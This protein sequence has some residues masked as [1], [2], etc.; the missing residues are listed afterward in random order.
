M[1]RWESARRGLQ[2]NEF[3]TLDPRHDQQVRQALVGILDELAEM[4][5]SEITDDRRAAVTALA[6]AQDDRSIDLLMKTLSD[7]DEYVRGDAVRALGDLG[8]REAADTARRLLDDWHHYPRLCAAEAC[9]KIRDAKAVGKLVAMLGDNSKTVR[10]KATAA[11]KAITGHDFGT[12]QQ[13]WQ[14]SLKLTNNSSP[15]GHDPSAP[16]DAKSTLMWVKCRSSEF[17][18]R[19]FEYAHPAGLIA[20]P[21]GSVVV[22][23]GEGRSWGGMVDYNAFLERLDPDGNLM[24]RN[25]GTTLRGS[26]SPAEICVAPDGGIVVAGTY[27]GKTLFTSCDG[28]SRSLTGKTLSRLSS[29]V[30]V[31]KYSSDGTLAWLNGA[32]N[33]KSD[34]SQPAI[35]TLPNGDVLLAGRFDREVVFG[36]NEETREVLRSSTANNLFLA[37][38]NGNDGRLKWIRCVVEGRAA[39]HFQLAALSAASDGSAV[40]LGRFEKTIVFDPE[41]SKEVHLQVASNS[42][43]RHSDLFL[44]RFDTEGHFLWTAQ[45][46]SNSSMY[47]VDVIT[48]SDGRV[49]V[50]GTFSG[51]ALFDSNGNPSSQLVSAGKTDVFFG[52]WFP[53]GEMAW[54]RRAGGTF[55]DE[56]S[57]FGRD[58]VGDF[59]IVGTFARE[60][61]FGLGEAN[62]ATVTAEGK[63]GVFVA[64][65]ADKGTLIDA[66]CV[67]HISR[68][69]D[70][71]VQDYALDQQS[72]VFLAASFFTEAMLGSGS[73][74]REGL[75]SER[76]QDLFVAKF[77]RVQ[78]V[79][80]KPMRNTTTNE[81]E[82]S[83]SS[84]TPQHF[85]TSLFCGVVLTA[86]L[87]LVGIR[88]K[89]NPLRMLVCASFAGT[90]LISA[91]TTRCADAQVL[92]LHSSKGKSLSVVPELDF[93]S[94][95]RSAR[96]DWWGALDEPT[97]A[98][99]TFD[100]NRFTFQDDKFFF[101]LRGFVP[102]QA[103]SFARS[104][105]LRMTAG[106]TFRTFTATIEA[107]GKGA[108]VRIFSG[109]VAGGE[110]VKVTYSGD[111]NKIE[112][113]CVVDFPKALEVDFYVNLLE[114]QNAN[115]RQSA[116]CS[117]RWIESPD[118]SKLLQRVLDKALSDEAP[119]VR[120]AMVWLI[121]ELGWKKARPALKKALNAET[122]DGVRKTIVANLARLSR[123]PSTRH[124]KSD[125]HD[126]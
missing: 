111:S 8:A 37:R 113:P 58:D 54:V 13:K 56:A 120:G 96:D 63:R 95:T 85:P 88:C 94:T 15:T 91:A 49:L 93:P 25:L 2:P 65:F 108:W 122:H 109:I 107:T 22:A 59:S 86:L 110:N 4:L 69:S 27:A 52:Q 44:A 24:W 121:G 33:A 10:E 114:S 76:K 21:D 41:G 75:W 74:D 57:G 36:Q 40:L 43:S 23:G 18:E 116:V 77:R 20:M 53:D 12:D 92:G 83:H 31:A 47:P 97:F 89:R 87:A 124:L 17:P 29:L 106:T 26:C 7:E 78:A 84:S 98:E 115:V 34:V 70:N 16:R 60:A 67:G 126:E 64:R 68:A 11:L 112:E 42:E 82:P 102:D 90:L 71:S 81:L 19:R 105:L 62:E 100:G 99:V 6:R 35:T 3:C 48:Q 101:V 28:N 80:D 39:A 55:K 9:G 46:H 73:N 32:T 72:S 103:S 66:Q 1:L 45:G 50:V 118:N 125:S 14:E 30:F 123:L 117:L 38:C 119:G 51:T 5:I 79:E 61:T 104:T